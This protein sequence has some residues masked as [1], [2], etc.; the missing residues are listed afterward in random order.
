M[1]YYVI[2]VRFRPTLTDRATVPPSAYLMK[3]EWPDPECGGAFGNGDTYACNGELLEFVSHYLPVDASTFNTPGEISPGD[4]MAPGTEYN[5]VFKAL[6][7]DDADLSQA[8]MRWV[9]G[10]GVLPVGSLP[11]L[12]WS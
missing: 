6:V 9:Y 7:P 5:V 2:A 1:T 11:E 8:R 10:D 4:T 3:V 12:P